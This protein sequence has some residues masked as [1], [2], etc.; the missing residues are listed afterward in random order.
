MH[1]YTH[2]F[3]NK[4]GGLISRIRKFFGSAKSATF[5]VAIGFLVPGFGYLIHWLNVFYLYNGTN[6][7]NM[8]NTLSIKIHI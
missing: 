2:S 8:N 7:W 1:I 5:N 3:N 6:I 4:A